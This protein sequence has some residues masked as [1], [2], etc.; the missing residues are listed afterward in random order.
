MNKSNNKEEGNKLNIKK[1]KN[2]NIQSG[3]IVAKKKIHI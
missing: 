1:G 3:T 2:K